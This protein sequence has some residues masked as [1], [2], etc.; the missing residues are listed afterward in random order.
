M[1]GR[2]N[3]QLAQQRAET[4]AVFGKLYRFGRRA[5]NFHARVFQ[6]AR[7]IQRRLSAKLNQHAVG[8]FTFNHV[9]H[10]F[11][12]DGFKIQTVGGVVIG[13]DR[14]GIAIQHNRFDAQVLKRVTGMN[15]AIIK[16]DALPDAIR[17]AAENQ[18]FFA[19]RRFRFIH[20]SRIRRIQIRRERFKLCRARINSLI[21]RFYV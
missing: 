18:N 6:R 1:F 12:R 10:I 17:S 4:R 14:F 19:V 13:A 16:L 21:N 3:V 5:E 20:R 9:H 15:T 8:F 7:E 11:K 2:R